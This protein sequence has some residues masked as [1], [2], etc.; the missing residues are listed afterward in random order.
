M[1]PERL[2]KIKQLCDEAT[3]G[4]WNSDEEAEYIFSD[5]DMVAEIRGIGA[6]LH[7]QNNA[8]F[9]AASR[10]I[11]PELIAEVE[12]LQAIRESQGNMISRLRKQVEYLKTQFEHVCPEITEMRGFLLRKKQRLALIDVDLEIIVR[13]K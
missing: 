8:A 3:P 5:G 6:Y 4:P 12:L 9:I 13:G 11:V 7:T 2:A 10:E 1:T